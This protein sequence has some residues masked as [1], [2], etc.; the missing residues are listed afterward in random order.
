MSNLDDGFDEVI[1]LHAPLTNDYVSTLKKVYTK[2]QRLLEA[3]RKTGELPNT[4]DGAEAMFTVQRL[5]DEIH[6]SQFKDVEDL[7]GKIR[8]IFNAWEIPHNI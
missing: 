8:E 4:S 2:S 3:E 1:A 7:F 6:G 5:I